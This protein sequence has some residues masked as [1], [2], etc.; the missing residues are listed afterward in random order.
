MNSDAGQYFYGGIPEVR[1]VSDVS[2]KTFLLDALK[3]DIILRDILE[4][5]N[6]KNISLFYQVT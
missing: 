1:M 2:Y 5:Y 4:A 3:N 6:I